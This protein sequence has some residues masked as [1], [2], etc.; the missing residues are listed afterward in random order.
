MDPS[1]N[2]TSAESQIK[3]KNKEKI[4]NNINATNDEDAEDNKIVIDSDQIQAIA[5]QATVDLDETFPWMQ[6]RKVLRSTKQNYEPRRKFSLAWVSIFVGAFI[7]MAVVIGRRGSLSPLAIALIGVIMIMLVFLIVEATT[8]VRF[9]WA[10]IFLGVL[11][12]IMVPDDAHDWVILAIAA[13]EFFTVLGY[14]LH[15]YAFDKCYRGCYWNSWKFDRRGH[16]TFAYKSKVCPRIFKGRVRYIGQLDDNSRPHGIG[17]WNDS[18]RH[19]ENIKGHWNHGKLEGPYISR[20]SGTGNMFSAVRI[21]YITD[22]RKWNKV[23]VKIKKSRSPLKF[24]VAVVECSISGKFSQHFPNTY[25][26]TGPDECTCKVTAAEDPEKA[27]PTK[28]LCTAKILEDI[29]TLSNANEMTELVVNATG[30]GIEIPGL[31]PTSA[32]DACSV[33]INYVPPS[34][35][36]DTVINI[37]EDTSSTETKTDLAAEQQSPLKLS[38]KHRFEEEEDEQIRRSKRDHGSDSPTAIVANSNLV[39][40]S[41]QKIALSGEISGAKSAKKKS[42]KKRKSAR[43]FSGV[44]DV[45]AAPLLGPKLLVDGWS[46]SASASDVEILFFIGGYN[47]PLETALKRIAQ[48]LA[49]GNFP[50]HIKPIVFSWPNGGALSYFSALK[51]GAK[52]DMTRQDLLKALDSFIDAGIRKIHI[53]VHS[54]GVQVFNNCL[55]HLEHRFCKL[56]E[57]RE[58]NQLYLKTFTML[59]PDYSLDLFVAEEFAKIRSLCPIVSLYGDKADKALYISQCINRFKSLGRNIKPLKDSNNKLLDMDLVDT[60]NIIDNM[61][62]LRHSYFELNRTMVD[63]LRELIVFQRRAAERTT[64]LAKKKGNVFVYVFTPSYVTN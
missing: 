47:S 25:L 19:G 35:N 18:S 53:M 14:I 58:P 61:H 37:D 32:E 15:H 1:E 7:A 4:S 38:K 13:L 9:V 22:T 16:N 51:E 29:V 59:N 26:L 46:A 3:E 63:D 56:D 43:S 64:R 39:G 57:R 28:C 45:L 34:Q 55:P 36:L 54:M 30:C 31:V 2:E 52:S 41:L 44:E 12:Y 21:G 62:A 60:T 17:E 24:G 10:W 11:T 27:E 50:P 49:V 33:T 6:Y 48:M 8:F 42:K 23:V 40:E 20:E 5:G